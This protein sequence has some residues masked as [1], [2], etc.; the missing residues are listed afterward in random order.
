M[1]KVTLRHNIKISK[2]TVIPHE[3]SENSKIVW[4]FDK[5]DKN[6]FF[7]FDINRSDFLHKLVLDKIISYSSMKWTEIRKQTHDNGKSKHHFLTEFEN[8]S[9]EA[10]KRII[11][12]QLTEDTDRIFSFAFTNLLRIIGL[13]DKEK[14]HVIWYD[15]K[16]EFYP[17]KK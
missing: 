10:Q 5:I 2:T 15:P 7:A 8:F 12:L 11:K 1:K 13:R 17:S 9:D 14:F 16:H 4:L 6:G 3:S